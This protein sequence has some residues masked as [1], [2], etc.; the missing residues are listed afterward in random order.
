MKNLSVPGSHCPACNKKIT[1]YENIPVI[2]WLLLRGQ[3]SACR[4]KISAQYPAVELITGLLFLAIVWLNPSFTLL[5]NTVYT[6]ICATALALILIDYKKQLLPDLLLGILLILTLFIYAQ[7]WN[8]LVFSE[9]LKS[10]IISYCVLWLLSRLGHTWK[11][12]TMMGEGDLKL[13][14]I[15]GFYIE[16][17]KLP[18]AFTAAFALFIAQVVLSGKTS[19]NKSTTHAFGPAL[20]LGFL[21]FQSLIK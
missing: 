2:S 6:S 1:W 13:V 11:G 15:L 21:I 16:P 7:N 20:I 17:L 3:C 18:H 12:T 9:G 10:A 5:Q 19:K 14:F 8:F 4:S